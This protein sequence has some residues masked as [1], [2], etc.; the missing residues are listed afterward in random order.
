[1]AS[2]SN[3]II[4]YDAECPMCRLYT[5]AFVKTGMLDSNGRAAY[6]QAEVVAACPRVNMQRAVNEI[7]LVNKETG[8]VTYGVQSLFTVLS[9]SWPVLK[10]LFGCSPFLAVMKKL[11]AFVS[12]NRRVIIPAAENVHSF[13]VQPAFHKRYRVLYLLFTWLVTSA[14]LSLYTPLLE[15]VVPSFGWYGELAVCG[16]QLLFQ[17]VL[18]RI[19]KPERLWSYLGNM[20]TISLAGALLLLPAIAISTRIPD[21]SAGYSVYFILVAA[22]MLVEHV[23]RSKLLGLGWWL[24]VGWVSYR[25][26]LLLFLIN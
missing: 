12:Y 19:V 16:G 21:A 6:Q 10:P 26:I 11:Y 25:I 14:I 8:E 18:V 24:T 4:L 2:L 15:G 7:A 1:M 23:R 5:G 22:L 13:S 17:G 3:H 9:A 20:M